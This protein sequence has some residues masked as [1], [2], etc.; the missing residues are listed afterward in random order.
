MTWA[1]AWR[2]GAATPG[3]LF[4]APM[5]SSAGSP[6]CLC[7]RFGGGSS[8]C[9]GEGCLRRAHRA[10]H[11]LRGRPPHHRCSP[12][13]CCLVLFMLLSSCMCRERRYLRGGNLRTGLSATGSL[14]RRPRRMLWRVFGEAEHPLGPACPAGPSAPSALDLSERCKASGAQTDGPVGQA[15]RP[16]W[17]LSPPRACGR[18]QPT[19]RR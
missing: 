16:T 3:R 7:C 6:A 12:A 10:R 1:T 19:C 15:R 8:A 9:T 13:P 5:R 14:L 17:R 18:H 2:L 11:R 4:C